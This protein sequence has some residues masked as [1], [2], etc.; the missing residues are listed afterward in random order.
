[1]RKKSSPEELRPEY[2]FASMPGG[3]RG[4]YVDAYRDGTNIAILADDVAS[5][6][7]TDEAVNRALRAI[8]E[9]A[10]SLPREDPSPRGTRRRQVR[11]RSR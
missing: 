2:D 10:R 9:A 8:M 5:T 7:P 3:V 6:F 1:M 11:K 4:K